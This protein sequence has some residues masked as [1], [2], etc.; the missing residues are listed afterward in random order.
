MARSGIENPQQ[1]FDKIV[2]TILDSFS[3]PEGRMP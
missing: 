1:G 2:G 3:W